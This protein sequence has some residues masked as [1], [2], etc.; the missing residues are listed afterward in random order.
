VAL[1]F[2]LRA[3]ALWVLV[4][5]A[6]ALGFWEFTGGKPRETEGDDGEKQ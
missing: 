1:T 4:T 5:V 2:T 3:G 6:L